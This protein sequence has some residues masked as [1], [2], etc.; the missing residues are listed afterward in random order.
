MARLVGRP[1]FAWGCGLREKQGGRWPREAASPSP[2]PQ[3]RQ[4]S[5]RNPGERA[6]A[7]PTSIQMKSEPRCP[8]H[9]F[10]VESLCPLFRPLGLS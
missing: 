5:C 9:P 6:T 7:P 10:F 1:W 8:R 4:C 3:G 2:S